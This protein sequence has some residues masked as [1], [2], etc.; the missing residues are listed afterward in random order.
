M[1]RI[2][3]GSPEA[4]DRFC[5]RYCPLIDNIVYFLVRHEAAEDVAQDVFI[6]VFRSI[7]T[8]R[9]EGRLA[10]WI[11]TIAY[12]TAKAHHTAKRRLSMALLRLPSP[13]PVPASSIENPTEV[14]LLLAAATPKLTRNERR[15]LALTSLNGLSYQE[16]IEILHMSLSAARQHH[17]KAI[18]KLRTEV[19]K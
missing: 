3:L 5:E 17:H 2:S 9:R 13:A 12:N 11:S 15:I 14:R 1:P 7:K 19:N 8:F 6:K 16:A 18:V 4:W 10:A